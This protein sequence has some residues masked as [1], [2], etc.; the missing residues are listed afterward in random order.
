MTEY[1]T[2]SYQYE[3]DC[4]SASIQY[5][6]EFYADRDIKPDEGIFL[7]FTIIPDDKKR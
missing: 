1:Y 4:L 7:K 6:K 5:N 2:L 3:N